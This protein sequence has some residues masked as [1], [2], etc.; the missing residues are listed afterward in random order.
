MNFCHHNRQ[1]CNAEIEHVFTVKLQTVVLILQSKTAFE[2]HPTLWCFSF[3]CN[4]TLPP[5]GPA[6]AA[7]DAAATD[8][9]RSLVQHPKLNPAQLFSHCSLCHAVAAN[10][11]SR[12]SGTIATQQ[13][14][15]L[16]IT[17]LV[18]LITIRPPLAA[19]PSRVSSRHQIWW[20]RSLSRAL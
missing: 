4:G 19:Q 7:I 12:G 11:A 13:T 15:Q 10:Q 17:Q 14:T 2:P 16:D 9:C 20:E 1:L 5:D 8:F 18:L 6:A 3:I